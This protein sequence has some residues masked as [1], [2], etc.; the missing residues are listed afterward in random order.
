MIVGRS[1]QC[2]RLMYGLQF[3]ILLHHFQPGSSRGEGTGQDF[4][5]SRENEKLFTGPGCH[6]LSVTV[7]FEVSVTIVVVDQLPI[8]AYIDFPWV[9]GHRPR[10]GICIFP[11]GPT[12]RMCG[13]V[14]SILARCEY[15]YLASVR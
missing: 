4:F 1:G 6:S 3:S 10:G 2:V 8:L 12:F 14:L 15:I 7:V 9:R 13:F 5:F 11:S